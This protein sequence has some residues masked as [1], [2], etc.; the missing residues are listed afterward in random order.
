MVSWATLIGGYAHFG[1]GEEPLKCFD[2]M[3]DEGVRMD[4]VNYVCT[5]KACGMV[6]SLEIGKEIDVDIRKQGYS[7]L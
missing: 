3:Q 5:L 4:T 2:M 1:L 6:R 7:L